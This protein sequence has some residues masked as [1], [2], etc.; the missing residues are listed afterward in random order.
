MAGIVTFRSAASSG[1][2]IS[3]LGSGIHDHVAFYG[4]TGPSSAIRIN[5]FNGT[6][7]ISQ[8][9]GTVATTVGGSGQLTNT[10]RVADTTDTSGVLV[11]AVGETDP[12]PE[13]DIVDLGVFDP[14]SVDTYPDW[15][16][17]PSGTLFIEWIA[18]SSLAVQVFNA[19]LYA[20][21]AG[22]TITD[23]PPDVSVWMFE[24]NPS[25]QFL[26]D[27]SISGIWKLAHTRDGALDF[28]NHS[29]TNGWEARNQHVYVAGISVQPNAI[30]ALDDWNIAFQLQFI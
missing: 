13:V 16:N 28:V 1:V 30:G 25:G 22:G 3:H 18:P 6:T 24:I 17:R 11:K 20:F 2:V 21:D 9:D 29:N 26:T 12:R 7:F 10:A 27:T 23:N 15:D 14:A 5:E 8:A 19:K 4:D